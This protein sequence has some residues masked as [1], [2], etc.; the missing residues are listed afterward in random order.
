[1]QLQIKRSVERVPGGMML[2]PFGPGSGHL[3]LRALDSCFF[4]GSFTGALFAGALPALVAAGNPAYA[5]AAGPATVLVA[6]SVTVTALVVPLV[7]AWWA[8]R[9]QGIPLMRK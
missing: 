7:T 4:W 5:P 8:R 6:A 1:M 2:V 9:I 3:H